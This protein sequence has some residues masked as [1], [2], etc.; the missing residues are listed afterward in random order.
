MNIHPNVLNSFQEIDAALFSSDSFYNLS[1]LKELERFLWRWEKK[2]NE[3]KTSILTEME[4]KEKENKPFQC[5]ACNH[6]Y[7]EKQDSIDCC[8]DD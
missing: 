1:N 2:K 5:Y 4:E 3:L 7:A 8:M 6:Y